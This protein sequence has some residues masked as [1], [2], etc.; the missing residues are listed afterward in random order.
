MKK[1][2]FTLLGLVLSVGARAQFVPGQVLTAQQLNTQFALYLPLTGGTLSGPLVVPSITITGGGG[3]PITGTTG[4]G[5]FV[6]QLGPTILSP[7]IN[8]IVSGNAQFATTGTATFGGI[9]ATPVSGSTGAFTSLSASGTVSG[10]GFTA[11]LGPYLLSTA[12]AS[13]YAPIASPAFTGTVTIPAG[14]SISGY[15]TTASASSTYATIAQATTALAAT[16]GSISGVPVSG[17]SGAFTTLSAS[18]TVSGA[19]FTALLSSYAPMA[20]P[21]FTGT[22]T[23]PTGASIATPN[24]AGITSGAGATAGIVGQVVTN[25]ASGVS[26]TSNTATN[27]TSISLTAGDWLVWGSLDF[28]PAPTTV[29]QLQAVGISTASATFPGFSAATSYGFTAS[30]GA[31]SILATP[32][33]L[34]NLSAAATAFLVTTQIFTISTCTASGA[35]TAIRWH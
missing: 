35:I 25:S 31:G 12:A 16:G 23:I 1:I 15:L 6:L 34:L 32:L 13:T 5:S 2:L 33:V 27:I 29:M 4:T 28:L 11:L 7:T 3:T 19:G 8:G 10:A 17:A 20:S 9:T 24:I 14:A 30:A 21:T 22:V 18:G 26:L